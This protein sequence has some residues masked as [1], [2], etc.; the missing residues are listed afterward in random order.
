VTGWK[1]RLAAVAVVAVSAAVA[2]GLSGWQPEESTQI[3]ETVTLGEPYGLDGGSSVRV[4]DVRCV[5]AVTHSNAT[6]EAVS[7]LVLT[8]EARADGRKV[9][10]SNAILVSGDR[11]YQSLNLAMLSVDAGFVGSS[12]MVYEIS[13]EDIPGAR[14]RVRFAGGIVEVLIPIGLFDLGLTKERAAQL[15]AEGESETYVVSYLNVTTEV[16]P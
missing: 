14:L 1:E 12:P 7:Y 2:A 8:V 16:I 15:C 3:T 4:T 9:L 5:G 13:P 10:V 6:Y 11:E